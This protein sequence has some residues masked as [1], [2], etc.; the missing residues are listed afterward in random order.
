MDSNGSKV[1]T[2][3]GFTSS[4]MSLGVHSQSSRSLFYSKGRKKVIMGLIFACV[5]LLLICIALTVYLVVVASRDHEKDIAGKADRKNGKMQKQCASDACL[6]VASALKRNMNESVDPCKDFFH[7]SCDGWIKYNPIPPSLNWFSTFGKLAKL[8][9]EKVLLL[10]LQN[11][12]LPKEHAVWKTRNYFKS[13]MA[14]EE[15]EKTA[16]NE[17]KSLITGLGS[18]P[19]SD[20]SWNE[21]TWNPIKLLAEFQRD[22]S[23]GSPM[24]VLGLNVNPFNS[25]KHILQVLHY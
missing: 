1:D 14:E 25:S 19:L 8:N 13:C 4:T 18:W 16:L 2:E 22:F 5:T 3:P 12:E 21:S 23:S 6:A 20:A 10:L 17:V 11:D 7:Y 15:I 9:S 24:F